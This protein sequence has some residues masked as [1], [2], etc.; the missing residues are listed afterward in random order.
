MKTDV[1]QRGQKHIESTIVVGGN[2]RTR[3]LEHLDF[4][5]IPLHNFQLPLTHPNRST[6]MIALENLP[7]AAS[8]HAFGDCQR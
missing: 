5:I 3:Q 4:D 2:A 7:F 6:G 1:H 8:V